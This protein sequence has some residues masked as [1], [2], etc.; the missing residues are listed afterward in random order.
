MVVRCRRWSESRGRERP[1]LAARVP[2]RDGQVRCQL[3]LLCHWVLGK[4]VQG[5]HGVLLVGLWTDCWGFVC[6]RWTGKLDSCESVSWRWWSL[7]GFRGDG[8]DNVG[9]WLHPGDLTWRGSHSALGGEGRLS[10]GG[11]NRRETWRLL[12]S[13]PDHRGGSCRL[14]GAGI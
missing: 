4:A 2:V 6:R 1:R 5:Q 3:L 10:T 7:G 8:A 11:D 12:V 13:A 14:A 9:G